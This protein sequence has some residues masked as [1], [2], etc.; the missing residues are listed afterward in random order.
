MAFDVRLEQ[1]N[2]RRLFRRR[3]RWSLLALAPLVIIM[4]SFGAG[5]EI[6]LL[7]LLAKRLSGD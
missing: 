3:A 7:M 2:R 5:R 4:L 1:R 6:Y